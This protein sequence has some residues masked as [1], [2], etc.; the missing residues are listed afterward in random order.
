[1]KKLISVLTT[2]LLITL[3]MLPITGA[4]Q[5]NSDQSNSTITGAQKIWEATPPI[6]IKRVS[7]TAPVGYSPSQ[8]RKA[9]GLDQITATGAGQTVAIVDAYGSPTI[10]SDLAAFSKQYSLPTASLTIAYPSGSV[11]KSN[12]GW[13][14]ET[15]MDVEWVHAIAPAANI[16]L[17]V[18]KSASTTDLVAAIDYATNHGAK[19]VSNSWGGSEF[20]GESSYDTHFNHPGV[21]YV[22]SSGDNGSGVEWPAASP[23]VLSVGGTTLNIDSTGTYQS[24]TAWSGSGGGTSSYQSTPS[25][26]STWTKVVGTKR[27]VP[28]VS[29]I[30]DPNTGVAVYDMTPDNGQTGWFQVGGTSLGAPCWAAMIA[31]SDQNRTNGL[32]SSNCIAG[33]YNIAGASGSS[34]YTTNYN[35]ITSGSNGGYNAQAGYD[36]VTGIGSSKANILVP[37]MAG[38][39]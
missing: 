12:G 30:A 20:S 35:D 21:V 6:H 2:I 26:Q 27:G 7:A 4:A 9:Y 25:Y 24:E 13:A 18:A 11:H 31:L 19:V 38:I 29:F 8:I 23:Y 5:G 39:Q 1:M 3:I 32:S 33:L 28:D 16:L 22:A 37:N 17:C 10:Q 34:S 15:S 36:L 14:L